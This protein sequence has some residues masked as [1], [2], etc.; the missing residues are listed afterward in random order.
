MLTLQTKGIYSVKIT[1][2]GAPYG[3]KTLKSERPALMLISNGS[4]FLG[5]TV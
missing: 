3:I 2:K 5:H 1:Q 4:L